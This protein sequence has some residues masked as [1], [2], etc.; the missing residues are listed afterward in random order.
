MRSN[1]GVMRPLGLFV[2]AVVPSAIAL[3]GC[4]GSQRSAEEAFCNRVQA[5]D[6]Q[7]TR[8]SASD[9]SDRAEMRISLRFYTGLRSLQPPSSTG[10]TVSTWKGTLNAERR[11]W[12]MLAVYDK[13]MGRLIRS[14]DKPRHPLKLPSGTGPTA[15]TITEVF[16]Q[17]FSSLEGR[18]F[19]RFAN[20]L[21]HRLGPD[22][23]ASQRVI[24]TAIAKACVPIGAWPPAAPTS[25][26]APTTTHR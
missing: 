2:L 12:M 24:G 1:G 14:Y 20:R 11:D 26:T 13:E 25:R 10:I 3:S 9:R 15:A 16:A 8:Q 17:I 6:R 22:S 23:R 21:F 4:A 7:M 19:S 18:R 5:L